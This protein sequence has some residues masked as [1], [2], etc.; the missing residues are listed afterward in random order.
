MAKAENKSKFNVDKDKLQRTHENI[1][2]DS[3]MEMKYFR[4]VVL[5]LWRSGYITAFELQKKYEL[6][7]KY[8]HNGKTILPITYVSDFYIEYWDGSCAVID[9]KGFADSMAKLKRKMFWYIYPDLNY[10][11]VCYSKID[12]GWV[13]YDI[14]HK[15]RQERKK[16]KKQKI[17]FKGE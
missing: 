10:Y 11:W 13:D 1:V 9:I 12:G 3:V 4:D 8:T 16:K 17:G 7:A 6:Q 15:N 2:F 5:P 14:V